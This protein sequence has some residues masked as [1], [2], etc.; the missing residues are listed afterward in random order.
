MH[1]WPSSCQSL[2]FLISDGFSMQ[3]VVKT[4]L[5]C[6]MESLAAIKVACKATGV[7][8]GVRLSIDVSH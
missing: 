2:P 6:A 4:M 1:F 8:K 5:A 3:T 7:F